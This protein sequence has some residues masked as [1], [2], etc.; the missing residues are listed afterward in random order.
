MYSHPGHSGYFFD[1]KRHNF[2]GNIYQGF[3]TAVVGEF[4]FEYVVNPGPEMN[5]LFYNIQYD[6][7]VRDAATLPL[8]SLDSPIHS[9][10]FTSFYVYNSK[11][12]CAETEINALINARVIDTSVVINQFRDDTDFTGSVLPN[13]AM[14]TNNLT[15]AINTNYI[16]AAKTAANRSRFV[17][18][19]LIIRL[20]YSNST[21]NLLNLYSANAGYRQNHR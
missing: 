16:N 9:P 4:E 8:T 6:V 17:D 1:H 11:Q 20:K 5:K 15:G 2:P 7:Q 14:F 19:Y 10:G 3:S 12:I 21:N 13:V 18:K